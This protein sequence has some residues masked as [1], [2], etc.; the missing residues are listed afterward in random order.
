MNDVKLLCLLRFVSCSLVLAAL[1]LTLLLVDRACFA[2]ACCSLFMFLILVS[3]SR[4]CFFALFYFA[5]CF[6]ALFV[7]LFSFSLFFILLFFIC[8]LYTSDAAD[9]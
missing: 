5:L 7:L 3:C 4:F 8:L 2:L 1:L 6:F 9:E